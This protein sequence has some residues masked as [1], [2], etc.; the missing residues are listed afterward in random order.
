[1]ANNSKDTAPTIKIWDVEYVTM[2]AV[3][4]DIVHIY[5]YP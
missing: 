5:V 2:C 3:W 4:Y 1:M